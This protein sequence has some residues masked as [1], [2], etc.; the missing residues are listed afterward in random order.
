MSGVGMMRDLL[1]AT[2][3]KAALS[4]YFVALIRAV[5]VQTTL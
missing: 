5:F 1:L 2:I 4:R 3:S